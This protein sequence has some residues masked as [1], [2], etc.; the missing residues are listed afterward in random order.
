MPDGMFPG[1]FGPLGG[2]APQAAGQA[3]AA[4]AGAQGGAQGPSTESLIEIPKKA[5]LNLGLPGPLGAIVNSIANIHTARQNAAASQANQLI[6]LTKAGWGPMLKSGALEKSLKMAGI[7]IASAEEI[8][9][10]MS[11]A[12][13]AAQAAT[14]GAAGAGAGPEDPTGAAP[15]SGIPKEPPYDAAVRSAKNPVERARAQANIFVDGLSRQAAMVARLK[16][17]TETALNQTAY[18]L[19]E[20]KKKATGGDEQALGQLYKLGEI[21]PPDIDYTTW[22]SMDDAQ[23]HR[24]LNVHSG[25]LSD[26]EQ[27]KRV[28]MIYTTVQGRFTNPA[29][30]HAAAAALAAGQ[31][32]PPAIE[33]RMKPMTLS[34]QLDSVSTMAKLADAGFPSDSINQMAHDVGLGGEGVLPPGFQSLREKQLAMEGKRVGIEGQQVQNQYEQLHGYDVTMPDGSTQHMPGSLQ[35]EYAQVQNT[36]K[37]LEAK[38]QSQEQLAALDTFKS[39]AEI[40]RSGGK[41]DSAVMEAANKK[42][43]ELFGYHIEETQRLWNWI[44]KLPVVGGALGRAGMTTRAVPGTTSGAT[45]SAPAAAG[46]A[47]GGA[48]LAGRPT[49]PAPVGAPEGSAGPQ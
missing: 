39:L 9:G 3:T 18:H 6:A 26:V 24:F 30:A 35:L 28:D 27:A 31:P 8:H 32:L 21:K 40:K 45:P 13:D 16:G 33:A 48:A 11:G 17:Q 23:K 15:G 1:S 47:V 41:V 42:V 38:A 36:A 7:P 29:D 46:A 49:T 22:S 14:Q 43:A 4:A 12:Q 44:T 19:A 5:P 2:G 37:E 20:L 10:T 34:E 25:A